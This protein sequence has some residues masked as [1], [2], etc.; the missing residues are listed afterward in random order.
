MLCIACSSGNAWRSVGSRDIL[1]VESDDAGDGVE[2]V[3]TGKGVDAGD[4][5]VG[6]LK[7]TGDCVNGKTANPPKSPPSHS[8]YSGGNA[9]YSHIVGLRKSSYNAL[10]LL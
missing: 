10:S 6:T 8:M 9:L 1:N 5:V 3:D 4:G 2:S 7:D